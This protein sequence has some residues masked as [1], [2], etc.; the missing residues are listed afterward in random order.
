MNLTISQKGWVVI[1]AELRKKYHLKPGAQVTM[2]DYGGVLSIVPA[3]PDPIK[4]GR[5]L[6]KDLPSLTEELLKERAAELA[7]EETR[8]KRIDG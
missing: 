1:P 7:R 3:M 5:G 2:V 4:Q 6:L 8:T